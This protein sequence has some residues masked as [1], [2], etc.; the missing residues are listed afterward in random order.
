MAALSVLWRTERRRC[1][2]PTPDID[3]PGASAPATYGVR[4]IVATE[5][6]A[7]TLAGLRPAT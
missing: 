6:I 4:R 3:I 5:R 1:P 7:L 2:S